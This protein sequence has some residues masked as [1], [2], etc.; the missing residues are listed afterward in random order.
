MAVKEKSVCNQRHLRGNQCQMC[1][2]V[3][4][5]K[6]IFATYQQTP[7]KNIINY[8]YTY[9]CVGATSSCHKANNHTHTHTCLLYIFMKLKAPQTKHLKK[10]PH[11]L[12]HATK[13]HSLQLVDATL[14]TLHFCAQQ[15]HSKRTHALRHWVAA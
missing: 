11:H 13:A 15:A 4:S 8:K 9:V 7:N 3:C 14:M 1:R 12:N 2:F 5:A 6:Q 10:T